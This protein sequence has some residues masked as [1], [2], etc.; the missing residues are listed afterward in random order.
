[1]IHLWTRFRD[2]KQDITSSPSATT[3]VENDVQAPKPTKLEIE[4]AGHVLVPAG[5]LQQ[6]LCIIDEQADHLV[7]TLRVPKASIK[8]NHAMLLALSETSGS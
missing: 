5:A 6:D 3:L 1:M 8:A 7:L 4:A 2:E